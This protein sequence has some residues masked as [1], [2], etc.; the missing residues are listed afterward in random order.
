MQVFPQQLIGL[1][2]ISLQTGSRLATTTGL[3]VD[4]DRLLVA[5]LACN[6]GKSSLL[7]LPQDIRQLAP[8][9]ILVDSEE[10]LAEPGDIVRVAPLAERNWNP[11]GIKVVTDM[12]RPVGK[13][14]NYTIAPDQFVIQKLHVRRPVWQSLTGASVIVDRGQVLDVTNHQIVV[15]DTEMIAGAA[16]PAADLPH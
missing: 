15:R 12:S 5:A 11:V 6:A 1:P 14:E 10:S 8:Q 13:V 4:P 16:A 3:I 2:V 9:G 7:L